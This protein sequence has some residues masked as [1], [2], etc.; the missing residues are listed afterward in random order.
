M[1]RILLWAHRLAGAER[2]TGIGRYVVALTRALAEPGVVAGPPVRYEL[3]AGPERE[4]P[5]WVPPGVGVQRL[6]PHRQALH[7]AWTIAHRPRIERFT[8]PATVVHSLYPGFPVPSRAPSVVTVHDTFVLDH[9]EW[10]GRF[11]GW[12]NRRALRWAADEAAHLLAD[13]HHTKRQLVERLGVEPDRVTVVWLGIDDRFSGSELSQAHGPAVEPTLERHGLARGEY[14]LAVGAVNERKNF[15]TLVEC[16]RRLAPPMQLVLAGPAGS[17]SA[18]LQATIEAAGVTDRVRLLGFVPDDDLRAL[19]QGALALVHP[20]LDE[21]FGF[22]P[23]EAMAAGVPAVVSGAGSLAEVVADA[24][25]VVPV[26][27]RDGWAAAV[28][29]LRRDPDH[30]AELI[31]RGRRRA[32][33]FTWRDTGRAPLRCTA[34]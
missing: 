31:E 32:Q 18:E 20:S 10:F 16:L 5:D 11:E 28:D 25:V 24:A 27:D 33:R 34:G 1:A 8:G 14:L 22:T 30:R 4:E 17:A 12:A 26:T 15:A 3:C 23:L 13:S 6:G 19:L 21:G 2:R 9:P 29:Q 7:L